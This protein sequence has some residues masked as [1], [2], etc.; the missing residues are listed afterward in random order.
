VLIV[1]DT[2]EPPTVNPTTGGGGI[3]MT[4][5]F[6]VKSILENIEFKVDTVKINGARVIG[7]GSEADKWRSENV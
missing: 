7:D 2:G 5:P 3:T 4:A 6:D 1:D